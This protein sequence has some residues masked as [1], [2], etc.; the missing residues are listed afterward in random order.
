MISCLRAAGQ[1]QTRLTRWAAPGGSALPPLQSPQCHWPRVILLCCGWFTVAVGNLPMSLLLIMNLI[2]HLP[3][4][5]EWNLL[6]SAA[7]MAPAALSLHTQRHHP[8]RPA[9][10]V[11]ALEQSRLLSTCIHWLSPRHFAC[12]AARVPHA[13]PVLSAL[14]D[15]IYCVLPS[16][17]LFPERKA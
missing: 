13:I 4:T 17:P 8:D 6:P 1:N 3:F 7:H 9:A 15:E 2:S 11:S 10:R 5:A 16:L 14:L 12:E